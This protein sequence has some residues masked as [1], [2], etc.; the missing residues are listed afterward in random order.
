MYYREAL[1]RHTSLTVSVRVCVCSSFEGAF[2]GVH[3]AME[4]SCKTLQKWKE[5]RTDPG[6]EY[7][8]QEGHYRTG[9]IW[10]TSVPPTTATVISVQVFISL[11]M[12]DTAVSPQLKGVNDD[13][14]KVSMLCMF[15][16]ADLPGCSL[17]GWN[18]LVCSTDCSYFKRQVT[19]P[20]PNPTH[21]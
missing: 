10:S 15:L 12:C 6:Q 21:T 5:G 4:R 14:D 8:S 9:I 1:N 19:P 18:Q 20:A 11:L 17:W 7:R 2:G 13:N 16:G 3:Q